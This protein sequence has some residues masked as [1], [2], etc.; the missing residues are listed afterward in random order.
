MFK[1]FAR[2][3]AVQTVVGRLLAL[4]LKAV[5][6]TSRM[7]LVPSD[8]SERLRAEA[9]VIVAL[10]HGQ[11]FMIPLAK[12]SDMAF[13]VLISRHGDGGI[14]AAACESFGIRPVRGSGG[15]PDQMH[16]KGAVTALRDLVRILKGGESV[17]LT[18]DI[19]KTARVAGLGI[20]TL[21]RLSGRPIFP[22]AVVS[23][24]AKVFDSWDRA[25]I[26]LPFGRIVTLLGEPIRVAADA[27]E[28]A[29]EAA[30]QRV[31]VELDRVHREAH[32]RL[33]IADPGRDLR[34]AA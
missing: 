5:G 24:R 17:T 25:A 28:T 22:A 12:P 30:R 18:A 20:V 19:P 34:K 29:L 15:R 14:N 16:K 1:R 32:E 33:G 6:A 23:D 26:G 21:A 11:H 8:L 31:E 9:P 7:D 4:Y 2:S 10:W 3:P 27:D 13:A